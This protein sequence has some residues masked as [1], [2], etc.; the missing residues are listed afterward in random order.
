[1]CRQDL[2][3]GGLALGIG[4]LTLLSVP[5]AVPRFQLSSLWEMRSSAFFPVLVAMFLALLGLALLVNAWGRSVTTPVAS[6]AAPRRLLWVMVTLV[7]Y[8][9]LMP[10]LGMFSSS[11][12]V[13]VILAL[14]LGERRWWLI[15]L[16][17]G[18]SSLLVYQLFERYLLILF[19]RGWLF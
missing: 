11:M 4:L 17:A 7:A 3:I 16:L 5:W 13:V 10:W 12:L 19:P 2:W 9:L 14:L 6:V 1:M 18:G 8:G 15:G